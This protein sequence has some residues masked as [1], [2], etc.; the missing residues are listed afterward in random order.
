MTD[1]PE[2]KDQPRGDVRAFDVRT[3]ALRWQFQVIPQ[4]G[5]YGVDTWEN[6]PAKYARTSGKNKACKYTGQAPVWAL[7][8]ADEELGYVYMPVTSPT[9]DMYGG[10]RLGGHTFCQHLRYAKVR[11]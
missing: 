5:E 2:A 6:A 10:H 8:S 4:G 7:F 11:H 1:S 9:S 3:G